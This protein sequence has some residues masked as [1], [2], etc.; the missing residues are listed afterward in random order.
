ME[1]SEPINSQPNQTA[2]P[3]SR[4]G[5]SSNFELLR[6]VCM[7][8]IIV[9]HFGAHGVFAEGLPLTNQK[10]IQSFITVGKLAVNVFVLISGYFL[11]KSKFRLSK[12]IKLILQTIFF[13]V[14]LYAVSCIWCEV[15]FDWKQLL[16]NFF[17]ISTRRNWFIQIYV[18]L[19]ALSPFINKVINACSKTEHL[20]LISI[21]LIAQLIFPYITNFFPQSELLWFITLYLMASY[22]RLYPNKTTELKRINLPVFIASFALMVYA[23]LELKQSYFA[24]SHIVCAISSLSLFCLFK[25]IKMPNIKVINLISSTT[26]GVYLF[27]DNIYINKTLWNE[28]IH[29]GFHAQL[30][31]FPLYIIVMVITV[32]AMGMIIDFIRQLIFIGIEKLIKKIPKKTN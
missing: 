2:Q 26:L 24:M 10:L 4:V 7:L 19:Y 16:Y 31:L 29:C 22:I 20:L 3:K 6:I 8:L 25:N 18:I 30:S 27:H 21:L 1:T 13:T 15:E 14:I 17:P 11:V 5:R 9:H 32:F 12:L 23:Y 28:I